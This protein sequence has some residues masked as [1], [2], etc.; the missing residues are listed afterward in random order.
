MPKRSG[1]GDTVESTDRE[2]LRGGVDGLVAA[3]TALGLVVSFFVGP[4]FLVAAI[5]LALAA[6]FAAGV[7]HDGPPETAGRTAL[8]SAGVGTGVVSAVAALL[9]LLVLLNELRTTGGVHPIGL[10]ALLVAAVYYAIGLA[11]G[12]PLVWVAGRFGAK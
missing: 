6:G 7:R 1:H 9:L 3:G 4:G 2:A 12:A 5:V 10:F 11:V 8:A